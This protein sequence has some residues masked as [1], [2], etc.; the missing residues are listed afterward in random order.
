[1]HLGFSAVFDACIIICIC[2]YVKAFAMRITTFI[3]I[4]KIL[5]IGVMRNFSKL[6]L[7]Y[8]QWIGYILSSDEWHI[9]ESSRRRF[10]ITHSRDLLPVCK[11]RFLTLKINVLQTQICKIVFYIR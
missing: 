8:S 7:R 3:S 6:I 5:K 4:L 9:R 11:K 2:L 1:M 10:E